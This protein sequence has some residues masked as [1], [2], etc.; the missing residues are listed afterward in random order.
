[1]GKADFTGPVNL[2][3]PDE[4]TIE[5]VAKLILEMT[6]SKSEIIH[7]PLPKDD[8]I[9]RRPDISLAKQVLGWQP[10]VTLEEGLPKVIEYFVPLAPRHCSPKKSPR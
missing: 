9:R 2:G 8:P 7:K 3:N 10:Q 1:M 5:D 6:G 4:R